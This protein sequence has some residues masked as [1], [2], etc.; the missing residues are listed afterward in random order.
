MALMK[1]YITRLEKE[2]V[3]VLR[4]SDKAL[5]TNDVAKLVGV[6][7]NTAE[8]HLKKLSRKGIIGIEKVGKKS[9]A[10]SVK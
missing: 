10:W 8:N 5:F 2:I 3:T 4:K 7:W 9:R 1:K 6:S